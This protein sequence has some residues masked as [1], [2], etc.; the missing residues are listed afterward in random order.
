[1]TLAEI[2]L[3]P[4]ERPLGACNA[5]NTIHESAF[6]SYHI[7]NKVVDLLKKNV[8]AEAIL[9]IIKDLQEG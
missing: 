5:A 7:I 4:T 9:E 6:R 1:M 3:V 8:P 2:R